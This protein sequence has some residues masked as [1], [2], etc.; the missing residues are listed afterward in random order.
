MAAQ[1]SAPDRSR[2]TV[3]IVRPTQ[4]TGGFEDLLRILPDGIQLI[5]LALDVQRGALDE[6]QAAIPAYEA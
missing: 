4:R 3:G 5:P 1:G 6:F 2:G